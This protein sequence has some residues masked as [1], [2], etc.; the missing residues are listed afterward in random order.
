MSLKSK[1]K[2]ENGINNGK[3]PVPISVSNE[4]CENTAAAAIAGNTI[5]FF[6]I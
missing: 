2:L 6:Q 1:N 3:L 5:F 4:I